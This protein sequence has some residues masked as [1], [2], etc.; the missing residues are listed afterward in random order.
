MSII[1]A[2]IAAEISAERL[3]TRADIAVIRSAERAGRIRSAGRT[4]VHLVKTN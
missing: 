1:T 2:R 4:E 3:I